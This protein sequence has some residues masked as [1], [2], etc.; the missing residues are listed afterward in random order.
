MVMG[1]VDLSLRGEGIV[2]ALQIQLFDLQL[3]CFQVQLRAQLV[4]CGFEKC[5]RYAVECKMSAKLAISRIHGSV[6]R[7]FS[8]KIPGVRAKKRCEIAKLVDR[9]GNFAAK[10][11]AK[12]IGWCGKGSVTAQSELV[13]FLSYV[14][15][16]ELDLPVVEHGS[17]RNRFGCTIPP[18]E[19]RQFSPERSNYVGRLGQVPTQSEVAGVKQ[20]I[21]AISESDRF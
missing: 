6:D 4:D 2:L 3:G 16:L 14:K 18:G 13:C 10:I 21:D 5:E 19:R 7:N 15:L 17:E 8:S 20:S 11:R 9:C 12:P 1:H